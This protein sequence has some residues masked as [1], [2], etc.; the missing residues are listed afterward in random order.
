MKSTITKLTSL[1]IQV[2]LL[3]HLQAQQNDT[4]KD[5]DYEKWGILAGNKLSEK[6]TWTSF[7]VSY[8][9]V[10]T[11]FLINNNTKKQIAIG[12]IREGFFMKENTFLWLKNEELSIMDLKT[13]DKILVPFVKKIYLSQLHN[14]IITIEKNVSSS[15][16][17][18]RNEYGKTERQIE[19]IGN[20]SLDEQV[21]RI[22]YEKT[23]D[24]VTYLEYIDLAHPLSSLLI[25]KL[26]SVSY[27]NFTWNHR[28]VAMIQRDEELDTSTICYYDEKQKKNDRMKADLLHDEIDLSPRSLHISESTEFIYFNAKEKIVNRSTN[29]SVEIWYGSDKL[30]YPI[31][32][33]KDER[34][35]ESHTWVWRRT[36]NTISQL[37]DT[38]LT[39]I[40]YLANANKVLLFNKYEQTTDD[41][42]INTYNLY[43]YDAE[44]KIKKLI[45]KNFDQN[46]YP[47]KNIAQTDNFVYY[48]DGNWRLYDTKSE[49]PLNLTSSIN[50][51]WDNEEVDEA[52]QK[53]AW[54]IAGISLD[55]K[56]VF[57]YDTYDIWKINLR[58]LLSKKLTN[59]RESQRIFRFDFSGQRK[60]T[61]YSQHLRE[62]D[63]TQDVR[64]V[65]DDL[66]TR[67]K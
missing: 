15:Q 34:G 14:K 67:T 46:T 16:I 21:N 62:L 51:H 47:I 59:G 2:F 24:A 52:Y 56:N 55:K 61:G 38:A 17:V 11:L 8:P 41:K 42:F 39:S 53:Q 6:G 50:T 54:G 64:L 9:S 49:T 26:K 37:T 30:I 18:I 5:I 35:F 66:E 60:D 20:Y 36:D 40:H 33:A 12:G 13:T 23:I 3:F 31:R 43:L 44:S 22:V 7:Y 58:T 29:D 32:K 63:D 1:L 28:G 57:I 19:G 48:A 65:I 25:E 4:V 10:D 27:Q 45:I